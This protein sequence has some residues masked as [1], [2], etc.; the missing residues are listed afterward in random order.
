M[1][2]QIETAIISINTLHSSLEV[3]FWRR[4]EGTGQTMSPHLYDGLVS[5][6]ASTVILR[7]LVRKQIQ[8]EGVEKSRATETSPGSSSP[9]A[10]VHLGNSDRHRHDDTL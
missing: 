4:A 8:E 10:Q 6:R 1:E 2:M 3:P 7:L 9:P 5:Q